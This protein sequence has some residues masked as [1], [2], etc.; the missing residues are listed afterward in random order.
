M[1][2]DVLGNT[3]KCLT[4]KKNSFGFLNETYHYVILVYAEGNVAQSPECVIVF[5]YEQTNI[6]FT[7]N[8]LYAC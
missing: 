8:I 3:R 4:N 5:L 2:I 6:F 1:F 7:D